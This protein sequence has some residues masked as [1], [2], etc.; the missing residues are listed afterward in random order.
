M[1]GIPQFTYSRVVYNLY[2]DTID[3]APSSCFRQVPGKLI[4][5]L[6]GWSVKTDHI[7]LLMPLTI[8]NLASLILMILVI[9]GTVS[10]SYRSD[11][12]DATSLALARLYTAKNDPTGWDDYVTYHDRSE[13]REVGHFRPPV[14]MII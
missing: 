12:V 9:M 1:P 13:D 6:S 4:F 10:G 5:Q 14:Y 11:P 2:S 8:V 7:G 3:R